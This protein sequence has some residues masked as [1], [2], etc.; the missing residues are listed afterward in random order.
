MPRP[1]FNQER[2]KGC[3]LCVVACKKNIIVIS[4]SLNSK[5][6]HSATCSDESACIGCI[7]CAKACPDVVI[8]IYK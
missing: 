3:G 1:V 2:C 4:D 6:Y 5:G 8:E 7:M